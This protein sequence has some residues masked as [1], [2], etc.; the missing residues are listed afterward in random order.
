VKIEGRTDYPVNPGGICPLGMGGLQLLYNA[1]IRF[2][3]P[4]KRVGPRGS[5]Q[6]M[7]IS[8]DEALDILA[9]RLT[10]LRDENR[11][12]AV[13]AIDGNRIDSTMSLLVQRLLDAVGSPNYIR[14][15]SIEDTYRMTNFLMTG[16]EGPMAYDLENAD[17]ILSF[18]AGLL[19]GWG[20]PGRVINAWQ[21][22]RGDPADR[23]TKIVQVESR[24]SNTASKADQWVAARPG[25]DAALALGLAHVIIKEG[26]YDKSFVDKMAFGFG[27]GGYKKLVLEKYSPSQAAEITGLSPEDIVSLA[28]AFAKAKAP[29]AVYGK[30]K[31]T[32]LNGSLYECMAV[33]SLNALVGSINEP[34]GVL[35]HDPLPLAPLPAFE[36][37]SVARSGLKKPRLD[38]AD[39]PQNP[40]S[41]SLLNN[42]TDAIIKEHSSPVDTLLVFSANPAY[43]S[44][45]GGDSLRALKKIPFIVSFSPYRD[46]TANMAD[47]VLPDHHYLEKMDDVVWPTGLQYPLFGLTSPV[48]EPIYNTQNTGDTLIA[49]SKRIGDPVAAAFPW[50][51]YEDVLALRAKGLSES[52]GGLVSWDESSPAWEHLRKQ[53]TAK[54]D[55]EDFDDMWEKIQAGGLWYRPAHKY[56]RS[57]KLFDTSTGKF[58]LLSTQIERALSQAAKG[59]SREAALKSMNVSAQGDEV[60]LPHHETRSSDV[61]RQ[62][63]PLQL[64]PYELINLSSGWL[65]NPPHLN[66]TLFDDELRKDDSFAEINPAT[67]AEYYLR[68]GDRVILETPKGK[69]EVRVSLFDGAMP[70]VVYVPL[71]F[72][73]TAYDEFSRGKGVNPM[74]IIDAPKDPLSGHPVWWD[75]PVKLTKV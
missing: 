50:D 27:D 35:V 32:S 55:Y 60:F 70:G 75:T 13:A 62:A 34:G 19:E 12:E 29:V 8:W 48:I 57:G 1:D 59:Q 20:A 36:A 67:A 33:Q 39:K 5:G 61:D 63:Y 65:P 25:T 7:D 11:P 51:S 2:P 37:D 26:L 74:Q 23:K 41:A 68:D 4:M 43:T 9:A 18:G 28:K 30:G 46:E 49:L 40:F 45:D 38:E 42:F 47:L 56:G 15:P 21:M 52:E 44:P 58:E 71:G 64:V 53:E 73:H 66:K 10:K 31:G 69:A 16:K 6:F 3:A 14:V 22:W 54:P 24:A 72:G 17:F